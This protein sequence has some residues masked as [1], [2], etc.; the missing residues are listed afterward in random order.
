MFVAELKMTKT[1]AAKG[2]ANLVAKRSKSKTQET[3]SAALILPAAVQNAVTKFRCQRA[4]QIELP[5]AAQQ[6]RRRRQ[7]WLH[8]AHLSAATD[9]SSLR[10]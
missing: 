9:L 7:R 6:V 2:L 1:M 5:I 4:P 10:K 8:L 3:S